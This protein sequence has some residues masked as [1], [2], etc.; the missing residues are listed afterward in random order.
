MKYLAAL[1][2]LVALFTAGAQ[3]NSKTSKE[4][5]TSF[6][7]GINALYC[8]SDYDKDIQYKEAKL[9]E[10]FTSTSNYENSI[11]QAL[12]E[13]RVHDAFAIVEKAHTRQF[14][15]IHNI[16]VGDASLASLVENTVVSVTTLQESLLKGQSLVEY[17]VGHK[18]IY[19]FVV[20]KDAIQI[21]KIKN[22]FSLTARVTSFRE[23]VYGCWDNP[24]ATD[25]EI[26]LNQLKYFQNANILYQE[27]WKPIE[28]IVGEHVIIVPDDVLHFVPFD[29]LLTSDEDD[30]SYLI[31]NHQFSYNY[32]ATTYRRL[33]V[34]EKEYVENSILAVAPKFENQYGYSKSLMAMRNGLGKLS[35]NI[36]EAKKVASM[37]KGDALL[38]SNAT[39]QNFI[40]KANEYNILHLSTHAKAN[41]LAGEF[42]Y[43]AFHQHDNI[44]QEDRL[45]ANELYDLKLNAQLVVLSA[46]ETGIGAYK[47]DK[48][49]VSL[50]KGFIA[51]GA[52]S[53]IT[54]LWS[55]NDAQTA[56]LMAIFYKNLKRGMSKDRALRLAKLAY[57]EQEDM[58]A[59]YFWAGFV[60]SGDMRP[61]DFNRPTG[62]VWGIGMFLLVSALYITAR[63]N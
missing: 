50:E 12:L 58:V 53:T 44:V 28:K 59:P 6:A 7:C 33:V 13:G 63:F 21:V 38:G 32:S 1:L 15:N 42:S 60:P 52:K 3:N 4:N 24:D 29:A 30:V 16:G 46:C 14:D 34:S 17:Y 45:F 22:D 54:S 62:L 9:Q 41:E 25:Q 35:Y 26:K 36:P 43:I 37:L 39:K 23:G 40:S 48:G 61:I 27:L 57:L 19:S 55:V 18:N 5:L 10:K 2:W 47:K 11:E 49:V 51:A 20:N 8:Y 56:K 31:K